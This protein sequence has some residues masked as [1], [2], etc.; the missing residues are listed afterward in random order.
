MEAHCTANC[1]DGGTVISVFFCVIVGSTGLGQL[2]PPMT[3]FFAAKSAVAEVMTVIR[4]KPLIDGLSNVGHC[5]DVPSRGHIELKQV[6][7]A[8]PARPDLMVCKGYDINILPG[9]TM[10][11]CGVSGCGKV[12]VFVDLVL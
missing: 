10:A 4:R 5:P 12:C 9:Q 2:A 8:Y 1:M 11:L 7:F 6:F 3:A